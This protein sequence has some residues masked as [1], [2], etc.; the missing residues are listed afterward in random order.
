MNNIS[1]LCSGLAVSLVAHIGAA[2]D[3]TS[4]LFDVGSPSNLELYQLNDA[5]VAL[6]EHSGDQILRICYGHTVDWPSIRFTT[7]ALRYSGDWSQKRYLAVTLTNP[8]DMP[9]AVG[10]RIDS[11][12]DRH[13]GRQSTISIDAGAT[14]RWLLSID[15][16]AGIIGMRGQPPIKSA[17]DHDVISSINYPALNP[18]EI[19]HF[20]LF[21]PRPQKN[22]TLLLRKVELIAF[23]HHQKRAF[24]D[25]YGQY[26]GAQWPGKIYT[27]NDLKEIARTEAAFLAQNP[28]LP[29]YSRFGGWKDGPRQTASGRFQVKKLNGKWWLVDPDGY[30]FWSSGTTGVRSGGNATRVHGRQFCFEWL[31]TADDPLSRFYKQGKHSA[32]DFFQINLY[33]KYGEDFEKIFFDISARRLQAWGMNTIAN[34]S[35]EP[36]CQLRRVPYVMPI[37][38]RAQ[39]F[40]ATSYKMAGLTKLKHFPDPFDPEYEGIIAK[41][42]RNM[43]GCIG[44]PWLLGVFVD[45]ELP[46]TAANPS[47]EGGTV[48]IPIPALCVNGGE[49][50]IKRALIDDLR[51]RYETITALNNQWSTHFASWGEMLDPLTLTVAQIKAAEQDILK[52]EALIAECYFRKTRDALKSCDPQIL[53]LGARFSGR[54]TPEVVKICAKYCDVVSFNIYEELPDMRQADEMALAQDFPV[55]IGEF[56]FGALDRG[57]FH[58]GLRKAENQA[59]RAAKYAAYIENAA[60]SAWCV[61][62]HWFQYKDQP[63]TGRGDG[64]NYNIGFIS[65]TDSI[66]PEM[67]RAAREIHTRLYKLRYGG[68][69]EL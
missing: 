66:Y 8:D 40:V 54:F 41:H 62:A 68:R 4:V 20:Q 36:V 6:A 17:N 64:E 49:T 42:L 1:L 33:R 45:N 29:H 69:G 39:R 48:R 53:Y 7:D 59:D 60:Q 28:M 61:G 65:E 25:Q 30:L 31:P 11:S 38:A 51:Q 26:N 50:H 19:T 2:Q 9:V 14:I 35:D 5:T 67:S 12:A 63:L 37:N 23:E 32:I 46:W 27:D 24:V 21:M 56:H 52:L 47:G 57:M 44:D 13:R 10:L 3:K 43:P 16:D 22:H 58:T 34:W 55:M 15:A 18:E